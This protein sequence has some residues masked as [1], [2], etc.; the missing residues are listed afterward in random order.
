MVHTLGGI[1][2]III[3][4]QFNISILLVSPEQLSQRKPIGGGRPPIRISV[5]ETPEPIQ[6]DDNTPVPEME[7]IFPQELIDLEQK[8]NQVLAEVQEEFTRQRDPVD[9]VYQQASKTQS[10]GKG[11]LGLINFLMV[12]LTETTDKADKSEGALREMVKYIKS[13]RA[14][15][16]REFT[17]LEAKNKDLKAF[18]ELK[19]ELLMDANNVYVKIVSNKQAEMVSVLKGVIEDVTNDKIQQSEDLTITYLEKA[20]ETLSQ[21]HLKSGSERINELSAEVKQGLEDQ[22]DWVEKG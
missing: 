13:L 16:L 5:S 15:V 14:D 9:K 12:K 8:C 22:G 11:Q 20:L 4:I 21:Q 1:V 2:S 6:L 3:F 19:A 17:L 10:Q 7:A 18:S